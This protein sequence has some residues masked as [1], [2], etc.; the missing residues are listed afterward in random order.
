VSSSL[1]KKRLEEETTAVAGETAAPENEPV[2]KDD[3]ERELEKLESEDPE[4][5]RICSIMT[6]QVDTFKVRLIDLLLL[7]LLV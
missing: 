2:E 7:L 5:L 4:M 6:E 3:D 1:G